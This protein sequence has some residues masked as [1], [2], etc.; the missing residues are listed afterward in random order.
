VRIKEKCEKILNR[1]SRV[2]STGKF[3]PEIDGLRFL[4]ISLVV[5]Y[6]LHG[7]FLN[8][9]PFQ[10]ADSSDLYPYINRPLRNGVRGVELFFVISG[11][12]LALPFANQY[13]NNGKKISLRSFYLKRVTRLEPPYIFV[14]IALF[15]LLISSSKYTFNTLFPSLAASLVYS[16]N[17]LFEKPPVITVVAW[18]LEIE[19]QFYLLAPFIAY[20]FTVNNIYVRRWM[21]SIMIIGIPFIQKYIPHPT[22]V[23]LYDYINFFLIGF[24][25][26]DF[27]LF[28]PKLK[29][30]V[31]VNI[32][33]GVL[34]LLTLFY[35]P[36]LTTALDIVIFSI[37]LFSFYLLVLTDI[38]WRG[39]FSKKVLTVIGGMCYSIYL[40]HYP[41]ISAIGNFSIKYKITNYYL[42]NLCFQF[43]IIVPFI[44]IIGGVFFYLI[45]RP[46]MNK[47]WPKN[48]W[49]HLLSLGKRDIKNSKIEASI[50]IKDDFQS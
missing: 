6:H 2:T 50:K 14:M 18:S 31:L 49:S 23:S 46:C 10:L 29:W 24:L 42:L 33:L 17:I 12:I 21:V 47:D 9:F 30:P 26:A 15:F 48:F 5:L 22:F 7:F 39:F 1:L 37:A 43:L 8:K 3:I 13:L 19:I 38:S 34:L 45:E 16:H 25:L 4:A 32:L 20:I 44:L 41:I 27:Y 35:Y 40:L 28:K 11:F 36:K